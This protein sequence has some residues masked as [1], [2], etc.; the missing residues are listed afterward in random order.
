MVKS[1]ILKESVEHVL[2]KRHPVEPVATDRHSVDGSLAA[3]TFF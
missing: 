3:I 2:K 1:G